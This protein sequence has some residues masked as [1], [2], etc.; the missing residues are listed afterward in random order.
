MHS[1]TTVLRGKNVFFF[2]R[3][4]EAKLIQQ[5]IWGLSQHQTEDH[6]SLATQVITGS[7]Q[8][9]WAWQWSEPEKKK[10][11][12]TEFHWFKKK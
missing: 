5:D 7:P 2:K 10:N 12:E 1:I 9:E 6:E 8:E 11:N 3:K 4:R